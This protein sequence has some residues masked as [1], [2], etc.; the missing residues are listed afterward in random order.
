MGGR[1]A[2]SGV[3][4]KGYKYGT[5][6][7]T[8]LQVDNIKFVQYQHSTAATI[9]LETMSAGKNRIYVVVNNREEL[10]HIV[11]YNKEGK[12]RR[13]I[14]L[15]HG[16]HHGFSPH[17]HE[18]YVGTQQPRQLNKSDKAYVEKVRRIWEAQI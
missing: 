1:G 7:K 13:R 18:G 8:L 12:N 3:S 11:F 10:K 5:E 14:D 17:V 16:H 4:V 15:G 2:A 9:P 6:F